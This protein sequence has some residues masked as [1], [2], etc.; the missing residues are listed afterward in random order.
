LEIYTLN[1]VVMLQGVG[2]M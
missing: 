1:K 2:L